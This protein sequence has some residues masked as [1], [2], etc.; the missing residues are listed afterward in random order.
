MRAGLWSSIVH[1]RLVSNN[2]RWD[3]FKMKKGQ[4]RC[5]VILDELGFLKIWFQHAIVVSDTMDLQNISS[6]KDPFLYNSFQTAC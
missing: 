1:V 2:N 6:H 4:V 3:N 5:S